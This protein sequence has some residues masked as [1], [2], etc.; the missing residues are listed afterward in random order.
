MDS[1]LEAAAGSGLAKTQFN[2]FGGPSSALAP[3]LSKASQTVPNGSSSG[4]VAAEQ[5]DGSLMEPKSLLLEPLGGQ[6]TPSLELPP[7]TRW[8]EPQAHRLS[9][10]GS[11]GGDC[12]ASLT[13]SPRSSHAGCLSLS[14]DDSQRC[15]SDDKSATGLSQTTKC[16]SQEVAELQL[17]LAQSSSAL[18]ASQGQLQALS[19]RV[20]ELQ[21]Q[22]ESECGHMLAAVQGELGAQERVHRGR[23]ADLQDRLQR[24]ELA[25]ASS[26]A[27]EAALELELR[28]AQSVLAGA[29]L[30]T[31]G[32]APATQA[33][34]Q[35]QLG[36]ALLALL[37][38]LNSALATV[39]AAEVRQAVVSG[40]AGS[41]LEACL[42]SAVS[43]SAERAALR[44]Q[45]KEL[46]ER[47]GQTQRR[48]GA[49]TAMLAATHAAELAREQSRRVAFAA[50]ARCFAAAAI[51]ARVFRAVEREAAEEELRVLS[52]RLA[53]AEAAR[54]V[55]AVQL[56]EAQQGLEEA[57][58]QLETEAAGAAVIREELRVLREQSSD[59]AEVADDKAKEVPSEDDLRADAAL[60]KP[61]RS[62]RSTSQKHQHLAAA[63][64]AQSCE[65]AGHAQPQPDPIM[66]TNVMWDA[67]TAARAGVEDGEEEGSDAAVQGR[68]RAVGTAAGKQDEQ[69]PEPAPQLEDAEEAALVDV[70][71][72]VTT[73]TTC[74]PEPAHAT[75]AAPSTTS[76][77][78]GAAPEPCSSCYATASA[79][80]ALAGAASTQSLAPN[81]SLR[82]R[83]SEPP[84]WVTNAAFKSRPSATATVS[85]QSSVECAPQEL[86]ETLSA[87][88]SELA[89]THEALRRERAASASGVAPGPGAALGWEPLGPV[90]AARAA[91][92]EVVLRA[93]RSV[94]RKELQRQLSAARSA[95][96]TATASHADAH[97]RLCAALATVMR[98]S[99]EAE[100]LRA[101]RAEMAAELGPARRTASRLWQQNAG[102]R[103]QARLYRTDHASAAAAVDV[104][105]RELHAAKAERARLQ[106]QLT[107][108]TSQT[109]AVQRAAEE[110]C[111]SLRRAHTDLGSQRAAL[112]RAQARAEAAEAE[113]SRLA[114]AAEAAAVEAEAARAQ[115]AEAAEQGAAR[116]ALAA[117]LQARLT[118][119]QPQPRSARASEEEGQAAACEEG[120]A[121]VG[122]EIAA[123]VCSCPGA[124]GAAAAA[125]AQPRATGST[126]VE[127][128]LEA[129]AAEAA[130]QAEAPV[131]RAPLPP[132]PL[133]A[134]GESPVEALRRGPAAGPTA[135][136]AAAALLGARPVGGW[137]SPRMGRSVSA[138]E[139]CGLAAA[140]AADDSDSDAAARPDAAKPGGG[141]TEPQPRHPARSRLATA[142]AA[143]GLG[144]GDARPL[145]AALRGGGGGLSLGL[146]MGPVAGGV[147]LGGGAWRS[148]ALAQAALAEARA[149]DL[150]LSRRRE[151]QREREQEAAAAAAAVHREVSVT[152]DEGKAG[153]G[154][155]GEVV[156]ALVAR[157]VDRVLT[158]AGEGSGSAAAALAEVRH[159]LRRLR[160]AVAAAAAAAGAPPPADATSCSLIQRE[161][162]ASSIGPNSSNSISHVS[163]VSSHGSQ[164]SGARGLGGDAVE[165]LLLRLDALEA[166][167]AG[168]LDGSGG[169][170]SSS[171]GGGPSAAASASGHCSS[172]AALE[173]GLEALSFASPQRR[174]FGTSTSGM[175]PGP[176][177]GL[178]QAGPGEAAT[179]P[180]LATPA[181]RE[182]PFA[183]RRHRDST[184]GDASTSAAAGVQTDP[185]E[186][187]SAAAA[188]AAVDSPSRAQAHTQT[189]TQTQ[190]AV[191]ASGRRATASSGAGGGVG[192]C[193]TRA[194]SWGLYPRS[195]TMS[196]SELHVLAEEPSD[197]SQDE[198][199]GRDGSPSG[200]SNSAASRQGQGCG[201]ARAR[202]HR[203]QTA[204]VGG[205]EAEEGEGEHGPL[206]VQARSASAS[207]MRVFQN[208]VFLQLEDAAAATA[209]AAA[210]AGAA[211][212][213]AHRARGVSSSGV[214]LGWH[215][216]G[217]FN[218]AGGGAGGGVALAPGRASHDAPHHLPP[219]LRAQ[220]LETPAAAGVAYPSRGPVAA[221]SPPAAGKPGRRSMSGR[222][223]DS[224]A[225]LGLGLGLSLSSLF[226]RQA[227]SG[228]AR[229]GMPRASADWA[230]IGPGGPAYGHH[231]AR[232]G[233]G[234]M[235]RASADWASVG[236]SASSGTASTGPVLGLDGGLVGAPAGP[237]GEMLV[238][239]SKAGSMGRLVRKLSRRLSGRRS[240]GVG[241]EPTAGAGGE[242]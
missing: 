200:P 114:A 120:E 8:R 10:G 101:A 6:E 149:R 45:V 239:V 17:A 54:D 226:N 79:Q 70:T 76:N 128:G 203:A 138:L 12:P 142:G 179:S 155:D 181:G 126:F 113:R 209:A 117:A 111:G 233:P 180:L 24:A 184:D 28:A 71:A 52:A 235:P 59:L 182:S 93:L 144:S 64:Q 16:Q 9:P 89:A 11:S 129:A 163:H 47:L 56:A 204:G 160:G 197:G 18:K 215:R 153:P 221:G 131:L 46:Y 3:A 75:S 67:S 108:V 25:A 133:P 72:T 199:E 158:S 193:M 154:A 148:W 141:S 107:D 41:A 73:T 166:D 241:L 172:V 121:H 187:D 214:D 81:T 146:G 13:G 224:G 217:R 57:V 42:A 228:Q 20:E 44:D 4:T 156:R 109:A 61:H 27:R 164:C 88:R 87:L 188:A 242:A 232:R 90:D 171:C 68:L 91:A 170:G 1:A 145:T 236:S 234:G 230:A 40:S 83:T 174:S 99:G 125:P 140:A 212:G 14:P 26:A 238:P 192:V 29:G 34:G 159:G 206:A 104:L 51:C 35:A 152:E 216:P 208:P 190:A 37:P 198:G 229:G 189:Q 7:G 231:G 115:L 207:E 86:W 201:Q 139:L 22:L 143:A 65:V 92:R 84:N 165:T 15:S 33:E 130:L 227:S 161:D 98:L 96:A 219:L 223:S 122:A 222:V 210:G 2:D 151:R 85:A 63:L 211:G 196:T 225:S 168:L 135:A 102:L 36:P 177:L 167:V 69:D 49:A 58:S 5:H 23:L 80:A 240:D 176:G 66:F 194:A 132:A 94:E 169:G 103:E 237:G 82:S 118:E 137:G 185:P 110:L 19:A 77:G 205:G 191:R 38:A 123:G 78:M 48:T 173:A 147:R 30:A 62:G 202:L 195:R 175:G 106:Q 178:G 150:L 105:R 31:R 55:L 213:Q 53:E 112:A 183:C 162:S 39:D 116:D 97:A 119:L 95:A 218:S 50:E 124:E 60:P 157:V 21:A 186:L 127:A 74:S 32:E 100:A 220:T 134:D 136:A 43:A